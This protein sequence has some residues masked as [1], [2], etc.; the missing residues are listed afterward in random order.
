MTAEGCVPVGPAVRTPGEPQLLGS[1]GSVRV[2]TL[3]CVARWEAEAAAFHR[4]RRAAGWGRSLRERRLALGL[5]R[6]VLAER[7][8]RHQTT[9]SRWERGISLPPAAVMAAVER[10]LGGGPDEPPVDGPT[11]GDR[12][13]G[14]RERAGLSPGRL[15]R[16][17]GVDRTTVGRIEA[18]EREPSLR[19]L[20]A[21]AG[22]LGCRPSQLLP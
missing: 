22:A 4:R 8:G 11:V 21:L 10:H 18:G 2:E 16:L 13:R 15:G 5:P 12:V 14:R 6:A 7:L 3:A 19:M 9:V 1:D 17:I 20:R